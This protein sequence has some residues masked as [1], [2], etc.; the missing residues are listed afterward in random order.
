[1]ANLQ[2]STLTYSIDHMVLVE[3]KPSTIIPMSGLRPVNKG[4][5]PEYLSQ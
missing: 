5:N 2:G 3:G 4:G 1:M